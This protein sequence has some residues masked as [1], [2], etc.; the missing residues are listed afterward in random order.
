[1]NTWTALI[2][3]SLFKHTHTHREGERERERE[4][5]RENMMKLGGTYV[6]VISGRV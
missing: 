1:M 2:G 3:L 5:E 4:R 6:V